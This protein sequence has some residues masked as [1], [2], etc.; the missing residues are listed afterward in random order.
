MVTNNRRAFRPNQARGRGNSC[1]GGIVRKQANV[2]SG[3]R[4]EILQ[5]AAVA[6]VLA[7]LPSACTKKCLKGTTLS[8][9]L[10]R[11]DGSSPMP[12]ADTS[13]VSAEA[14][15]AP[16]N[17]N[18]S[19]GSQSA[20]SSM[21]APSN[22]A[23]AGGSGTVAVAT[24]N[25]LGG[26]AGMMAGQ[27]MSSASGTQTGVCQPSETSCDGTTQLQCSSAGDWMPS[28][29]C[30]FVCMGGT[31]SGSCKPGAKQCAGNTSQT[32]SDAGDWTD[33]EECANVCSAGECA[34]QCS[35]GARQCSGLSVQICGDDGT[36]LPDETCPYVCDEG[37]C[38]GECVPNSVQ[39]S[40][41]TPETCDAR[42][43]W[44][45]G[46]ACPYICDSGRCTGSCR[47]GDDRC[48]GPTQEL[49]SDAGQWSREPIKVG[50]C[51]VDCIPGT[52][53]CDGTQPTLCDASGQIQRLSVSPPA[54]G[55]VCSP[56]D[57]GCSP[58]HKT[59][60][61]SS[62]GRR[63]VVG[64]LSMSCGAVCTT[65]GMEGACVGTG[66]IQSCGSD[67][68]WKTVQAKNG[69]CVCAP[70]TLGCALAADLSKSPPIV[71]TGGPSNCAR[72]GD[73]ANVVRCSDRGRWES[74]QRCGTCFLCPAGTPGRNSVFASACRS[75][76]TSLM[77]VSNADCPIPAG[78]NC[79]ATP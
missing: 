24:Q 8:N 52:E 44:Q 71:C 55:A 6:M 12:G 36:W 23:M 56:N 74:I 3:C 27:P 68:L 51:E 10:C 59:T 4:F 2:L 77:C 53:G 14:A 47:P 38:I 63:V 58:D 25:G 18:S 33:A 29:E 1:S 48:M 34:G 46:R 60:R 54:C 15:D 13:A 9:G 66:M 49:C 39:C 69:D 45:A 57:P 40:S 41:L 5:L 42:G 28:V 19:A 16:A 26:A 62:D 37:S 7:A 72:Q 78:G 35:P 75:N 43:S 79:A 31:C 22:Q 65:P 32:C 70:G 20:P 11:P 73:N 21:A 30:P 17:S 67:G 61:C 76:G 64:Q 50:V